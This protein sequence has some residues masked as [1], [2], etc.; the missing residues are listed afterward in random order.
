[1][2]AGCKGEDKVHK[3]TKHATPLLPK[4]IMR[5]RNPVVEKMVHLHLVWV[6]DLI[7]K[8]M[9]VIQLIATEEAKNLCVHLRQKETVTVEKEET[10]DKSLLA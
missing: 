8:T 5:Q 9:L 3:S 7:K 4:Q 2:C 6:E 1:M 10:D